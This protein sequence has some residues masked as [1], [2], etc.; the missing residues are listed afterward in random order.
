MGRRSIATLIL[1]VLLGC[2]TGNEDSGEE[3]LGHAA[4]EE[5]IIDVPTAAQFEAGH[6]EGAI[7]IPYNEIGARIAEVTDDRETEIVLYCRTGARAGRAMTTLEGLGFTS[8]QNA[9]R[10]EDLK[11]QMGES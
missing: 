4:P 5:P 2:G 9:G 6:I 7:S 3:V 8:A 10:Y 11:A 1:T